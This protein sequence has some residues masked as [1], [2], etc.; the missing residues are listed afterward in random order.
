MAA[1]INAVFS[2]NISICRLISIIGQQL[3]AAFCK[4]RFF[5][6][7]QWDP[8][9]GAQFYCYKWLIV[10]TLDVLWPGCTLMDKTAGYQASCQAEA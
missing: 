10:N 4:P 9:F 7:E 1:R 8:S 5:T 3:N 2:R 6:W